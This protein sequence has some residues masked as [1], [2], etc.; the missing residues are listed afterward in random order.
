MAKT[1]TALNTISGVVSQVNASAL[2]HPTFSAYLVEV[3]EGTKSYSADLW[4]SKTAEEHIASQKT[5]SKAADKPTEPVEVADP[6][7]DKN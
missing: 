2:R 7:K 4:T 5:K 6:S 3:P 1:I